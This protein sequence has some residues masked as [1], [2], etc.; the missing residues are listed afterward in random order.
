M[1][2]SDDISDIPAVLRRPLPPKGAAK[3]DKGKP[4]PEAIKAPSKPPEALKKASGKAS[5]GDKGKPAIE[6]AKAAVDAYGFKLDTV[7]S[8]AAA[9]Y[10]SKKGATVAEVQEALG[11]LQLNL[12]KDVEKRGFT[13]ERTK[14]KGGTRMITRYRIVA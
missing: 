11:S 2:D 6:P 3:P 13:I 1:A 9:M 14:E 10:A 12:L 7:R 5:K 4:K 8:K